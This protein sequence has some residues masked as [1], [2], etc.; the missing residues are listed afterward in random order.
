MSSTPSPETLA[1]AA[2]VAAIVQV[3]EHSFFTYAEP[4]GAAEVEE[5][6]PADMRWLCAAIG[7]EGTHRRGRLEIAMPLSL[8]RELAAGFGGCEP[9]E[10]T[11]AMVIDATGELSNMVCGVWLTRTSPHAA[12]AL[13]APIVIERAPVDPRTERPAFLLMNDAPVAVSVEESER[14]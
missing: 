5:R 11:D 1:E 8:A 3:A 7:F 12:F 14:V 2:L 4:C 10:L 6:L 13:D 9:P